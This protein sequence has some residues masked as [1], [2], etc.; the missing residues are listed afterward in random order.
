MLREGLSEGFVRPLAA[1][2]D[3]PDAAARAELAGSMLLGLLVCRTVIG[4]KTEH[5]DEESFVALVGRALQKVIDGT[6]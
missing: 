6:V 4:G 1:R 2:L 3:G 5:D